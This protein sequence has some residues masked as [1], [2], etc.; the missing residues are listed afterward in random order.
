MVTTAAS[1]TNFNIINQSGSSL[2]SF[3]TANYDNGN[4]NQI[5]INGNGGNPTSQSTTSSG[6]TV[7]NFTNGQ[8]GGWNGV[9]TSTNQSLNGIGGNNYNSQQVQNLDQI[10][11]TYST[12]TQSPTVSYQNNRYP[13]ANL[14]TGSDSTLPNLT[15]SLIAG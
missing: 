15:P 10:I 3:N 12:T 11:N 14:P 4:N 9:I 5:I 13:E 2:N 8:N 6:F 1:S 7:Q